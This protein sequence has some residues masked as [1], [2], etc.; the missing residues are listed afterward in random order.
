MRLAKRKQ[1]RDPAADLVSQ[2]ASST[3]DLK[4]GYVV[5]AWQVSSHR[6]GAGELRDDWVLSRLE[7]VG[8]L[9]S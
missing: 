7:R 3:P 9:G 5:G 2:C 1:G 8:A 4:W 6:D